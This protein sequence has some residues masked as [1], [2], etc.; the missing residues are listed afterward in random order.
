MRILNVLYEL[1]TG[2]MERL[3]VTTANK[4]SETDEVFACIVSG[5]YSEDLLRSFDEKVHVVI[6]KRCG[7]LRQ[8]RYLL[9]IIRLAQREN[10]EVL[11]FHDA[12]IAFK[13]APVCIL[14]PGRKK[15]YTIHDTGEFERIGRCNRWII[16]ACSHR[17]IAISRAV[18]SELKA[19]HVPERKV[20]LVYNSVDTSRFPVRRKRSLK[21]GRVILGQVARLVPAKK[22]QDVL[23]RAAALLRERGYDVECRFAGEQTEGSEDLAKLK[24]LAG[25]LHLADRAVFFGNV[26]DVQGFLNDLDIFVLPSRYEG[27]GI[28]VVEALS[29]GLPCVTSD[30]PGLNELITDTRLGEQFHS[31]DAQDLADKLMYVIE[32]ESDYDPDYLHQYVTDRFSDTTACEELQAIY[33]ERRHEMAAGRID[34]DGFGV[35][36]DS[37]RQ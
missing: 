1:N 10:V 12:M 2:G 15:F 33:A 5:Q 20:R 4:L 19:F 23:L 11:H 27:F 31:G 30:V 9:Q 3:L 14:T 36:E 18:A 21:D 6:L 22:G 7:H 17:V 37:D 24:D 16:R 32:H 13:F 8:I 34:G 25:Q 35:Y 28:S 29:S 26:T